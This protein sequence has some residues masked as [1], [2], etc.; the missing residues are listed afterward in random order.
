VK[1]MDHSI[2]QPA[3]GEGAQLA[4]IQGGAKMEK[5]TEAKV[6]QFRGMELLPQKLAAQYLGISEKTLHNLNS[7]RKGP[8]RRKIRGKLFYNR[9]D[10]DAYQRSQMIVI[11]GVS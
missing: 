5:E 11:E 8:T 9:A 4:L 1:S 7:L 3:V 10:L 2:F 6:I